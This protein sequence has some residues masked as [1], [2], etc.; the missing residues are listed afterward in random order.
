MSAQL[1]KLDTLM[2]SDLTAD[3]SLRDKL[4][5][6]CILG[7]YI[8]RRSNL[9]ILSEDGQSFFA[10]ELEY[11]LLE[12]SEAIS[13]CGID[14]TFKRNCSGNLA[15][16]DALLLYDLF[17]EIVELSLPDLSAL[18]IS[19]VTSDESASLKMLLNCNPQAVTRDKIKNL[20]RLQQRGGRFSERWEDETL[21]LNIHLGRAGESG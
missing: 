14:C 17:E 4:I 9:V 8:K 16:D 18:F 21:Y 7:T 13:A 2:A 19:V 15:T 3:D 6:L 10:K 11:C 12:S 5:W 20:F 1:K